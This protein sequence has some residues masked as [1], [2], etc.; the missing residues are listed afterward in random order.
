MRNRSSTPSGTKVREPGL[1]ETIRELLLGWR[2]P[3]DCIQVDVT[4]RCPG[5]CTYC[6]H[7]TMRAGWQSRYF[8]R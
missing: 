2:R 8:S 6:P 3:L 4:S 5:R 7:T 1:W